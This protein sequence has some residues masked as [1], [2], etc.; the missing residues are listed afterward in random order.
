MMIDGEKKMMMIIIRPPPLLL[1]FSL[2]PALEDGRR[3][4]AKISASVLKIKFVRKVVWKRQK[5]RKV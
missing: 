5:A 4:K 1:L 3:R 2:T